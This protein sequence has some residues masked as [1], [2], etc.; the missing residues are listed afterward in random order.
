MTF[1]MNGLPVFELTA[2]L[3]PAISL[4]MQNPAQNPNPTKT[5]RYGSEQ[6]EVLEQNRHPGQTF[7]HRPDGR[8]EEKLR[9][10]LVRQNGIKE[11]T[12]SS[13]SGQAAKP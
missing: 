8:I 11:N 6:V 10:G 13:P 12:I 3:P 5:I 1:G 4:P 7:I 9:D 2:G